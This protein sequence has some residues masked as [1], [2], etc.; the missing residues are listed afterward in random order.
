[1]KTSNIPYRAVWY[2]NLSANKLNKL[3]MKQKEILTEKDKD[4]LEDY[5]WMLIY[6]LQSSVEKGFMVELIT[7]KNP[8][9]YNGKSYGMK[10]KFWLVNI[11]SLLN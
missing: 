4:L 8:E 5:K 6:D 11:D 10:N 1:M 2:P 3:L 9:T 7:D